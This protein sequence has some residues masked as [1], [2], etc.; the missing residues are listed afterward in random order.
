MV[1]EITRGVPKDP[2]VGACGFLVSGTKEMRTKD[3]GIKIPPDEARNRKNCDGVGTL[4]G[5]W[6]SSYWSWGVFAILVL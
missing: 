1:P 3:L 5:D 2:P 4:H 6:T